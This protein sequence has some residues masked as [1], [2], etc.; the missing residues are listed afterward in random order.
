M[1][2]F[3]PIARSLALAASLLAASTLSACSSGEPSP[4]KKAP[5]KTVFDPLV[6]TEQRA[7]DVQNTVDENAERTRKAAEAQERG[8]SSP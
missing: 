3:R 6:Q 7:R 2:S 4:P 5:E 1:N 8:D